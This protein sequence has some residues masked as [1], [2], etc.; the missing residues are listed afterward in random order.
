M[1]NV[2]CKMNGYINEIPLSLR[3]RKGIVYTINEPVSIT[4]VPQ[5]GVR[6]CQSQRTKN[7]EGRQPQQHEK[8]NL[9]FY[10]LLWTR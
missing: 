7:F 6:G 5:I 10:S 8:Q 9:I 4:L 3:H 1:V 2:I